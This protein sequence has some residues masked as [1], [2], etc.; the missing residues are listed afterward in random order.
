MMEKIMIL[1]FGV[2]VVLVAGASNIYPIYLQKLMDHFGFS[3]AQINLY[4]SFIVFGGGIGFPINQIYDSLGPKIACF[5]GT[6]LLSGSFFVL[7][8]FFTYDY[9][10]G[11]SIYP[12]LLLGFIM[13]QGDCLLSST[14]LATNL[15]N[16]S[17]KANSSVV[18]ILVAN[19]AI[20]PS[21]FTTYRQSTK[22]LSNDNFY[23]Y[24]SIFL[25]LM[26][27]S[28]V[29]VLNNIKVPYAE[30]HLIK[31][32]QK[33]IEKRQIQWIMLY[34]L[35]IVSVFVFGVLFNYFED[36]YIVPLIAIYPLMQLLTF[37]FAA[38][39]S[40]GLFDYI[41][42]PSFKKKVDFMMQSQI[43][44]AQL[45]SNPNENNN[46]NEENQSQRIMIKK[47]TTTTTFRDL[48]FTQSIKS[49]L[50]ILLFI[51][52]FLGLGSVIS[53]L[54]NINFILKSLS[55][56]VHFS[57][58]NKGLISIYKVKELF[59]YVIL[60][61]TFNSTV[62]IA[63]GIFLD[64]LIKKNKFV[65][66]FIIFTFVGLVSQ[67]LGLF[68]QKRLLYASIA[69]AGATH[70]GYMAF[71]PIFIKKEFGLSNM[72]KLLGVLTTGTALGSFFISEFIFTLP[73]NYY[74]SKEHNLQCFGSKCFTLSYI[75]TSGCFFV[76]L[77]IAF[78]LQW[79]SP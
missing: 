34:N 64:Y 39:H 52:L 29:I 12:L 45:S 58:S 20:S 33:Y 27:L 75:I 18:G 17:F 44:L 53:N 66:Y 51:A 62:R 32:Y 48:D 7:H 21:I 22:D 4:V 38:M 77:G 79:L 13:G 5:I 23:L 63:S 50:L 14:A 56:K 60:Y 65:L 71:V 47:T 57:G 24:F 11:M 31:K 55:F 19:V 73:Y 35:L 9:F 6:I 70:G 42:Y 1:I 16:F 76:N 68:M 69:L 28:S 43:E 72:G 8:F 37:A 67:L 41:Y 10:I 46:K 40:F 61:F 2:F 54:N 78:V 26:G 74:A 3:I 30:D 36:A 59:F 25:C 49:P 15:K